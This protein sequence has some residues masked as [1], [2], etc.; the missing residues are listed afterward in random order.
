MPDSPTDINELFSRDPLKL[1]SD[2]IDKIIEE[3][4]K[5]RHLFKAGPA[6]AAPAAKTQ[7]QEAVS[8]LKIELDL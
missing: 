1:T 7:K 5:R 8:K 6:K 4:R 3:M 2:D